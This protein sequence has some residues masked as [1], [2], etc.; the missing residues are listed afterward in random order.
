MADLAVFDDSNIINVHLLIA[1]HQL[2]QTPIVSA[3]FYKISCYLVTKMSVQ[4]ANLA[5][6]DN[7]NTPLDH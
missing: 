6:F 1:K 2:C 5:V 7:S 4:M 3:K